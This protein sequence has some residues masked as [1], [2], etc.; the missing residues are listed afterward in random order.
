MKE[1]KYLV[2]GTGRCGTVFAARVLTS[3]GINCG[4]E[5]CF[6]WRG[7]DY[8]KAK[9]MGAIPIHTSETSMYQY[10]NGEHH[11]IARWLNE[12]EI[13]AESSYMAAPFIRDQCFQNTKFIHVVRNPVHVVNSFIKY[14][15]YFQ[16]RHPAVW[17]PAKKYETFIY[18][19]CDELYLD[20]SQE[21][22][23]ALYVVR[24]NQMIE[25]NLEGKDFLFHRS[26]DDLRPLIDFVGG[27]PEIRVFNDRKINSLEKRVPRFTLDSLPNGN[28]KEEFIA[29]GKKYGYLM[30]QESE[31]FLT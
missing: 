29:L 14:L 12:D 20:M 31:M 21:E 28:I 24:W 15:A 17:Q 5:C 25:R 16:Q 6:D 8:A 26:E 27:D 10:Q 13:V 11:P 22:R 9:L 4:H 7:I 30:S 1:L 2:V 3:L 19:H 18:S 23:A